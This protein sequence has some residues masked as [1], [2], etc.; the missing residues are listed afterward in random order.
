MDER[1]QEMLDHYQIKKTLSEYCQGCDRCDEPRMAGVYAQ[2]SWDDH[3]ETKMPGPQFSQIMI[4][5]IVAETESLY[6]MLGQSVIHV[7]GDHAGAETYFLAATRTRREDGIEMCNQLGG[8]FVDRL[9]RE[10]GH[11]RISHRTVVRDWSISLAVTEPVWTET[12]QLTEGQ[13]SN[14]DPCYA[15]LGLHHAG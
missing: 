15:V 3:G 4:K 7:Q 2:D 12:A 9:C 14:A 5:R 1:L 8:R 11:W 13:R 6:H 10:N